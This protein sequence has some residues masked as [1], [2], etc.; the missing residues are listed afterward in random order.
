MYVCA[1]SLSLPLL[2]ITYLPIEWKDLLALLLFDHKKKQRQGAQS[3]S[4]KSSIPSATMKDLIEPMLSMFEERALSIASKSL[5][6]S[7]THSHADEHCCAHLTLVQN[8]I[9]TISKSLRQSFQALDNLS[10]ILLAAVDDTDDDDDEERE[11]ERQ[12]EDVNIQR[13]KEKKD[14]LVEFVS[15]LTA[16]VMEEVPSGIVSEG[17]CEGMNK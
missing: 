13:E 9:R 14:L 2:P 16:V 8:H 5:S 4:S 7:G 11:K 1:D 17:E 12:G 3:T 6:L 10:L 15:L